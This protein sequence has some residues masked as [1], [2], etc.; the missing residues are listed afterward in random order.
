M[1][2]QQNEW[3]MKGVKPSWVETWHVLVRVWAEP[4]LG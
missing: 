2:K 3:A 4:G 1:K